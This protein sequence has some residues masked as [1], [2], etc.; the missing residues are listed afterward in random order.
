MSSYL[1]TWNPKKWQWHD[2]PHAIVAVNNN[3]KYIYY[4]SCGATKSIS[5]GDMFFLMKL[6]LEPKG[7]IGMGQI[8]SSPYPLKH[9]NEEKAAKGKIALRVDLLFRVLS[10]VPL[11]EL[12]ELRDKYN[13]EWLP[14]ASGTR[15]PDDI[16]SSLW[17]QVENI[18]GD[19]YQKLDEAFI[20]TYKEGKP[21]IITIKNYDR[22]PKARDECIV[23]HGYECA[24]CGFNFRDKYGVIGN[25]YIEVHHLHEISLVGEDNEI[26]PITDLRPVCSNCHSMLHRTRPAYSIDELKTKI[27]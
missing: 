15:V 25:N 19:K 5:A 16:S 23:Y 12:S 26:D 27:I 7:I 24:V 8:L 4:W 13:H 11:V 1:F 18:T 20:K 6:G 17:S 21:K 3:Q 14:Q 2:L 22:S 10:D 9:W